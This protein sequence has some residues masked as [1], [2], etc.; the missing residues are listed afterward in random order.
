MNRFG[1]LLVSLASSSWLVLCVFLLAACGGP[2][3]EPPTA[4]PANVVVPDQPAPVYADDVA[5]F[6]TETAAET[7][8]PSAQ[9]EGQV[10]RGAAPV[11]V[12][13]RPTIVLPY[14]QTPSALGIVRGGAVLRKTP[15]G[16]RIG[17]LSAGT[18][19]TITGKST[20]GSAYA[21]FDHDG[22][23]GWIAASLV[24]VF[25]DDDLIVVEGAAGPGPIAT[26]IAE[27]MQPIGPS[28]LE[29]VGKLLALPFNP[30]TKDGDCILKLQN[31]FQGKM[32]WSETFPEGHSQKQSHHGH[33]G[34]ST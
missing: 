18:T 30:K 1:E 26:L 22:A 4:I 32:P 6:T 33:N 25:G 10:I 28:V 2:G 20:D 14:Q 23:A 21:V 19:V 27:A 31:A 7:P 9:V 3:F 12:S 29:G 15:G 24:A 34:T 5:R 11:A 16:E 17:A 8:I 13:S